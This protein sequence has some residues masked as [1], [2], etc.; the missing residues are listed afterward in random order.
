MKFRNLYLL[1]S[2]IVFLLIVLQDLEVL[3]EVCQ[4]YF[5]RLECCCSQANNASSCTQLQY[6]LVFEDINH[7]RRLP[8]QITNQDE[9]TIPNSP[10]M[11]AIQ[12]LV[13]LYNFAVDLDQPLEHLCYKSLN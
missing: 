11:A 12:H 13:N 8:I 10:S 3:L 1:R 5:L 7:F 6:Y 9:C 2:S 4:Y